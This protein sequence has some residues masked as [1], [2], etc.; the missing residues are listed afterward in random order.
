MLY[1]L[2][3]LINFN[4][5]F[6]GQLLK[7]PVLIE[8]YAEHQQRSGN[9]SFSDFIAMHY[10]GQDIDDNDD[11]RDMQLPF[12]KVDSHSH[13]MVYI[14]G[15]VYTSAFSVSPADSHFVKNYKAHFHTN[16]SLGSVFRPPIA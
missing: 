6:L 13:Y 3:L 4:S 14:P 8:H 10:L 1:I 12:K 15:R 7:V 11:D 2:I 16:P 5:C 9:L